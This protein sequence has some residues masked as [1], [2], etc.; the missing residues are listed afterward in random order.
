MPLTPEARQIIRASLEMLAQGKKPLVVTIG[1]LTTQQH[2]SINVH[3]LQQNLHPLENPEVLFLGRHLYKSR[4]LQDGYSIE[5]I[6]DQIESALSDNATVIATHKL[7]ALR[8]PV[9]RH[10]RYGNWV[11]DEAILELSQRRPKAELF[12]VIPKG[13]KHKPPQP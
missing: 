2:T 13:D 11:H 6:L 1:A 12:S 8:N 9:P 5:D 3:R 4:A 10:D 7:T